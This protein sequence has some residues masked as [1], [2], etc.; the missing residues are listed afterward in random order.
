MTETDKMELKKETIWQREKAREDVGALEV[1]AEQIAGALDR[2]SNAMRTRPQ[3]VT[4]VPAIDPA[5]DPRDDIKLI[6]RRLILETCS[7]LAKAKERFR[8]AEKQVNKL[9][10]GSPQTRIDI[11]DNEREDGPV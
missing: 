3:L 8:L 10:F 6:D 7:E 4:E 5:Y 2:I 1:K 11:G 9:Q